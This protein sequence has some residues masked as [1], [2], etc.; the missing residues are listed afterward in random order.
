MCVCRGG[1]CLKGPFPAVLKTRGN[2]LQAPL[3]HIGLQAGWNYPGSPRVCERAMWVSRKS[4]S[5]SLIATALSSQ[6]HAPALLQALLPNSHFQSL[7]P[8][9]KE[10]QASNPSQ[11]DLKRRIGPGLR[12]A[13]LPRN[14]SL[15]RAGESQS[16]SQQVSAHSPSLN[17]PR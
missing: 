16:W 3:F 11:I 9:D 4:I 5:R 14:Y 7:T 6:P 1:G 10:K 13:P 2:R 15:Q 8:V 12:V 17:T